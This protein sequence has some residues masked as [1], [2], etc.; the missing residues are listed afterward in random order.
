MDMPFQKEKYE[1][2]YFLGLIWINS[3][4]NKVMDG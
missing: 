1:L 4:L 2:K 3:Y